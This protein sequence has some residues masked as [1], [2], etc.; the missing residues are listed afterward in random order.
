MNTQNTGL[1]NSYKAFSVGYD[2][3]VG[4]NWTVGG[5]VTKV[6]GDTGFT[7]GHSDNKEVALSAYGTLLKEDGQYLDLVVSRSRLD[8]DF[9]FRND[10]GY[11]LAGE[12]KTRGNV[13]SAEYGKRF[14]KDKGIY[15]DPSVQFTVGKIK[16]LNYSA[17][18]NLRDSKG[19]FKHLHVD[20]SGFTSAVGRLGISVGRQA[21]NYNAFAKLVLAHE[22]SGSFDSSFSAD[23]EPQNSKTHLDMKDTWC[24]FEVGGSVNMGE[25][26][27]LYGAFS[28]SFAGDAT[29][30]WRIDA[31]VRYSF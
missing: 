23:E 31:G 26:T 14:V 30:K 11:Q 12:Y 29:N 25:N 16:G 21:D 3:P 5:A 2:L 8:T 27:H 28:R 24:E 15:V 9:R 22:F 19:D 10:G 18:S 7:G 13:F 20:Q 4:G 1:S 6:D 17:A